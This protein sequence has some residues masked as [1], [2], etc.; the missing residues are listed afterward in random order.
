[1]IIIQCYSQGGESTKGMVLAV[2]SIVTVQCTLLSIVSD[3]VKRLCGSGYHTAQSCVS[4]SSKLC[5]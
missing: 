2:I 1:M 5:Q 4:H 3:S